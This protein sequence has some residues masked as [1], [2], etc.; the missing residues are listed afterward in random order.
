MNKSRA[1]L[2][3]L[4][5]TIIAAASG[6]GV[7]N[8][9]R[10]KNQLNEAARA[11]KAG[12]FAEAQQHSERALALN[13]DDKNA[14]FFIA[15][16]IH[17]QYRQ[18]VDTPENVQKAERA[19]RAYN[20]ILERDPN[21]EEAFRAIVALYG[22]MG[23][24][25]LQR[26]WMERRAINDTVDAHGRSEA[27]V[28]LASKEWDCSFGITERKENQQTIQKDG[29]MVIQFTKPKN[30]AD[31]DRANQCA[32]RGL[33]YIERA[34]S[35]EPGNDKAWGFKT[36]LLLEKRKLAEMDGK[37]DEKEQFAKMADEAQ[38]RTTELGEERR[39]VEEAKKAAQAPTS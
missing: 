34:I 32:T 39:K 11:Y 1:L 22:Y 33:E 16:S 24:H 35:L 8:R 26:Q 27:Y 4:C 23:Q 29:K 7:V 28:F 30:Q 36:N 25:D 13:P 12:R 17:A 6:C 21:N 31:F 19:I 3:F 38:K 5:L 14:P 37:L 18:G 2:I 20:K 15:R 10:A 9:I